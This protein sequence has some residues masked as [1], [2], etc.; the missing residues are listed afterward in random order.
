MMED[1]RPFP[2]ATFWIEQLEEAV[3]DAE[4]ALRARDWPALDTA[5]RRQPRLIHGLRN[6]LEVE[7]SSVPEEENSEMDGRIERIVAVRAGQIERLRIFREE[8]R[9]R[10]IELD[11]FRRA[12]QGA[13]ARRKRRSTFDIVR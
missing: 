12:A 7:R 4:R 9:R 3:A 8:V 2:Q 10:L 13:A 5:N 1:N 11:R 6:A